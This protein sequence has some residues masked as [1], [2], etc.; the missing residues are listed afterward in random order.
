MSGIPDYS[1][2]KFIDWLSGRTAMPALP[3]VY[4]ALFATMP[5]D[6]GTGY[7]E[8]DYT[9]YA[10]KGALST[11]TDFAAAASSGPATAANQAALTFATPTGNPTNGD[12]VGF[13]AFDSGTIAG[14]NL[15]WFDY[16]GG[17]D[18]L[19]CAVADA[20]TEIISSKAHGYAAN[21]R[22]V[23][24]AEFGGTLPTGITAGT[25]YYVMS[26]SLATD[27][28]RVSTASGNSGPVDITATG[29]CMVR[30]VTPMTITNGVAPSFG[31]GQIT[32]KAA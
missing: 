8:T 13:G 6:A 23:F 10:R 15:L 29:A 7:A 11:T 21:D 18:W 28:F 2:R 19:P 30:K 20:S 14:G 25:L 27:S 22:V 3:S 1:A 26:T 16:L 9:S 24:S 32:L 12:V 5:T 17:F 4:L 31:A